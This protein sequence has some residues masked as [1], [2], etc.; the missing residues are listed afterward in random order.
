[1]KQFNLTTKSVK[2]LFLLLALLLGGT[3]PT[4]ADE[5]TIFGSSTQTRSD[6]PIYGY[7]ADT[8]GDQCEFVVPASLLSSMNGKN[9]TG[10]KFYTATFSWG[11]NIPEYKV[12]LK[13][14]ASTTLSA[15]S[16]DTDATTV[17]TGTLSLADGV[18]TVTFA[19]PYEYNGGN[20]L[21]GTKV[22]K[23]G[24]YR[25]TNSSTFYGD[26]SSDVQ[27]GRSSMGG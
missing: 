9:I 20:L 24:S 2:S 13:E 10:L 5:L 23:T 4:W 8:S 6:L 16:G 15:F 22:S 14:V 27:C 21:I 19:E 26:T 11:T 12:Y 25:P 18:M 17:Y 3:S 1:M 7:N